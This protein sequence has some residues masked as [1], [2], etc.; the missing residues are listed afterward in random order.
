MP[1]ILVT[2]VVALLASRVAHAD[3]RTKALDALVD[4]QVAAYFKGDEKGFKAGLAKSGQYSILGLHPRNVVIPD[5][6]DNVEDLKI[7]RRQTAWNG[8]WGWSIAEVTLT[9]WWK[10]PPAPPDS[11]RRAETWHWVT[12]AVAERGVV[13]ARLVVA[14][15]AQP[16]DKF[17][18]M[19]WIDDMPAAASPPAIAGLLAHPATLTLADAPQIAL[20]GSQPSEL[21]MGPAAAKQ[22]LDAWRTTTFQVLDTDVASDKQDYQPVEITVDDAQVAWA[23]MRWKLPGQTQWMKGSA[24][25]IGKKTKTG[26]A[27][28]VLAYH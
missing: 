8:T 25:L 26:T 16:A 5:P 13:K 27:I 20:A 19:K 28:V 14:A 12:F 22:R 24:V 6:P 1:R 2:I 4:K 3:A 18:Y 10:K 23:P 11:K 15:W 17:T 21:A 7:A 9:S